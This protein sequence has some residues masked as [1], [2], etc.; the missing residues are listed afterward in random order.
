M[1]T[2]VTLHHWPQ[3]DALVRLLAAVALVVRRA[4]LAHCPAVL[5]LRYRP[6]LLVDVLEWPVCVAP[7]TVSSLAPRQYYPAPEVGG[8][9]CAACM[10]LVGALRGKQAEQGVAA[11]PPTI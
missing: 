7:S 8:V 5:A 9:P 11:R 2:L 10:Q 4:R 6:A 1:L 3:V